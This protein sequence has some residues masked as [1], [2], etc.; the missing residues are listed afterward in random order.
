MNHIKRVE[1]SLG[2]DLH[3]IDADENNLSIS[4]DYDSRNNPNLVHIS[5]TD[6]KGFVVSE[7]I[8]NQVQVWYKS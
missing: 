3:Q 6:L 2:G 1:Y 5:L 7:I 8:S 4:V